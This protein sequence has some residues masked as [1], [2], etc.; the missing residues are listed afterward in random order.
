MNIPGGNITFLFTDIE[1]STKLSQDYPETIQSALDKHHSVLRNAVE[2]KNGFIFE[3]VGD[4]FCCAFEKAEDAVNAAVEAQL[5]L[6]N[7]KWNAAVIKVRIGIHS[8]SAEWNGTDYMGYITLARAARVMSAAFGEQII[9]SNPTY[10]LVR[11]KF[12]AVKEK[13]VTFRDLGERRLKDVIQPIR[14]FQILCPGL[15]EDFPP[16]KTLDARP[17]NLPIQLTSFIG[18][19]DVMLRVKKLFGQTHLLTILGAGGA[20]KTRL[21]M[22]TA[23][24]VIDDFANGVFIAELASVSDPSFILQTLMSSLGIKEETGKSLEETLTGYLKDKEILIILDNCEHLIN[25]CSGLAEKLIR[26]CPSLKIIATSRE[27]LNCVGEQTYI[28][29]SL[30][31]PD[32]SVNNTAEKITNYESVRLFIE[33]ALSVNQNFRVNNKNATALAEICRRL[34]GIPLAIE[35]AAARIRVLS[36][37]KINERLDDRFNLLSGGKRTA[38]P[39]QQTLRALIDW[40]YDL[41]TEEEKVLWR[42]LSVFSGGWTLEAAEEICS[43]DNFKKG[44]ILDL[45]SQ[46]A[47]KSIIIFD[48]ENNRYRILET[49]KQYGEDKLN[50][51]QEADLI[52]SRYLQFY[53]MFS[54][55]AYGNFIGP[56]SDNWLDLVETEMD[57]LRSAQNRAIA[58]KDIEY[59]LKLSDY[60]SRFWL[61]RGLLQEGLKNATKIL[62][63]VSTNNYPVLR[64]KLLFDAGV[65]AQDMSYFEDAK[66]YLTESLEI[67]KKQNDYTFLARVTS[68]LGLV[69]INTLE[70]QKGEA[71]CIEAKALYEKT[72]NKSG[73]TNSLIYLSYIHIDKGDFLKAGKILNEALNQRKDL[74]ADRNLIYS[75][76]RLATIETKLGNLTLAA[77]FLNSAKSML[78]KTGDKQLMYDLCLGYYDL[79]HSQGDIKNAEDMLANAR[80]AIRDSGDDRKEI[81]IDFLYG[82][83]L[84]DKENY[85]EAYKIQ[86]DNLSLLDKN[87]LSTDVLDMRYA[88]EVF[89]HRGDLNKAKETFKTCLSVIKKTQA[90]YWLVQCLESLSLLA[91]NEKKYERSSILINYAAIMRK[92]YN[93]YVCNC[94]RKR[95]EKLFEQLNE[96]FQNKLVS[97]L[98]EID[99]NKFIEYAESD[100]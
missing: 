100:L 69:M 49:L 22:Q 86:N 97:E 2:S 71:L 13:D 70:Y 94:E 35:L 64:A 65:I 40:S 37:E 33:R 55:N 1:G 30:S 31:I 96:D 62:N 5:D 44:E 8:G 82:H 43:D 61:L 47:D 56:D 42:R 24:D 66:K 23:A 74:V 25:E 38:L 4:A 20:G 51:T 60:L 99:L 17:N 88:G 27:A 18:R 54:E 78:E 34:D 21:A 80:S 83:L 90:K 41:L 58:V 79:Y 36:V 6:A 72:G 92:I 91:Y 85:E 16:L 50:K 73:E 67:F 15:R 19:D 68:M 9:I 7:E 48:E 77:D 45:L 52:S 98:N 87:E 29:P 84:F 11:D 81:S 3:I 57:N 75:R 39:R 14:L 26:N 63:M 12:D 53:L 76:I 93:Y 46:L 28:L 59:C 32:A 95:F 10:E 89:I